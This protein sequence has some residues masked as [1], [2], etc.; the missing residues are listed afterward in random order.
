ME[1]INPNLPVAKVTEYHPIIAGENEVNASPASTSK[2][3]LVAV[4]DSYTQIL[5]VQ[6]REA[7]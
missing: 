3:G 2:A 1:R 4:G 6:S 5:R 7:C